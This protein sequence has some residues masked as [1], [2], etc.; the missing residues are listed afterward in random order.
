MI[1]PKNPVIWQKPPVESALTPGEIHVWRVDLNH[2]DSQAHSILNSLSEEELNRGRRFIQELH[3]RRFYTSKAFLR[4]ILSYYL[5][6]PPSNLQFRE[7]EYGK[8][9]L[10]G[11]SQNESLQFNMTHSE[12]VAL[13][14]FSR[15]VELGIDLE[16]LNKSL[17]IEPLITRCFS[18]EE[19]KAVI[20]LPISQRQ[21]AFYD[22][23]TRK[24]AYLKAFGWGL[25]RLGQACALTSAEIKMIS[26]APSPI[27]TAALAWQHSNRF[28]QMQI[29]FF[30][31]LII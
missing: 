30:H 17:Q 22:L 1:V 12:D 3:R 16:Y 26:F 6:I 29:D 8:P 11:Q 5:K 31:E 13:Y 15:E 27:Y 18:A 14:A 28:D 7:G 19:A 10:I 9:Y 21:S 4:H 25:S 24:E 23:W 2:W 20:A